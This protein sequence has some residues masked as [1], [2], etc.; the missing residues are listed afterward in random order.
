MKKRTCLTI[1]LFFI[2]MLSGCG[3]KMKALDVESVKDVLVQ[4]EYYNDDIQTFSLDGLS[5][6]GGLINDSWIFCFYDYGDNKKALDD[7]MP[8]FLADDPD[9]YEVTE[10]SN[11]VIYEKERQNTYVLFV[12]VDNTL[13]WITGTK[14]D[15]EEI[16]SLAKNMGYYR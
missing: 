15:K 16:R 6:I 4:T 11:Y 5:D 3:N 10:K 7:I 13:L 14:E 8:V 9:T 1:I 12:R 2:L